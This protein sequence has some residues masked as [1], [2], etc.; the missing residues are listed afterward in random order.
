V[1]APSARLELPRRVCV[2]DI[3]AVDVHGEIE[4]IVRPRILLISREGG[5]PDVLHSCHGNLSPRGGLEVLSVATDT[6]QLL[7]GGR[8]VH[9]LPTWALCRVRITLDRFAPRV[10]RI[11][12]WDPSTA[13]R[14][15][16]QTAQCQCEASRANGTETRDPAPARAS[17][18][19]H[20]V[21]PR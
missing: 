8:D 12:P 6:R 21:S 13:A 5:K 10:L 11:W 17:G 16:T 15:P 18:R 4:Q 3:G 20:Q 19:A 2:Y 14:R 1:E 9:R 7:R